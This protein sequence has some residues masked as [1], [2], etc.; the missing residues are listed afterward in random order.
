LEHKLRTLFLFLSLA[1]ISHNSFSVGFASMYSG[2]D[3]YVTFSWSSVPTASFD[4]SYSGSNAYVGT[5]CGDATYMNVGSPAIPDG[6]AQFAIGPNINHTYYPQIHQYGRGHNSVG[7]C[8]NGPGFSQSSPSSD[9]NWTAGFSVTTDQIYR[10]TNGG[11][12]LPNTSSIPNVQFARLY[13][14]KGTDIPEANVQYNIYRNGAYITT[15]AGNIYSWTEPLLLNSGSYTYEVRTQATSWGNPESGSAYYYISLHNDILQATDAT[16]YG[17]STLTWPNIAS[18]APNDIAVSRDGHQIAVVNKNATTYNDFDGVPGIV[19]SY[20][21]AP[22]N[23][24]NQSPFAFTDNGAS[25][26]NGVIKGNVRTPF[27]AAVSGVT[28]YGYARVNGNLIYDSVVTDASG[29]YQFDDLFYDTAAV[30]TIVPHKGLHH[31]VADTLSRRLGLNSNVAS[32]VDFQDTSVFTIQGQ[33]RFSADP[34]CPNC[35]DGGVAIYKD[36]TYTNVST[37]ANGRY[38]LAIQQEGTYT[39]KPLLYNHKFSPDSVVIHVTSD[40]FGVNFTDLARDTIFLSVKGG[41]GN[42]ISHHDIVSINSNNGSYAAFDTFNGYGQTAIVVPA[43]PYTV[44]FIKGFSTYAFEDPLIATALGSLPI[45]VDVTKRDSAT[46]SHVDTT[47]IVRPAIR[48]TLLTG[49]IIVHPAHTDTI[50]DTLTSKIVLQHRADFVYHGQ[51]TVGVVNFPTSSVCPSLN[52]GYI[53]EQGNN[54]SLRVVINEFYPYDSTSC[55]VD[56]GQLVIYD[57]VSDIGSAQTVNFYHGVYNYMVVP[58]S[59]NIASP[60]LK[61]LQFFAHVGNVTNPNWG[62]QILV[63]GHKPHTQTFVTKT[64]ELPFFVLHDPPGDAS[65]SFL[66]KDSSVSYNYS[67]SYQVGG[68]AGPYV[69]AKIGAGVPIPFTGVVIGA[70]VELQADATAG[71]D[72]THNSDVTTTFTASQQFSTSS[73]SDFV[74]GEGDVFVGGSFN[75]IYALTDVIDI[76]NCQVVRDTQLA[77]G[78]NGLATNYIYTEK[79]IRETLVPQLQVLKSLSHGDTVALIQSYIDVWNQVL[80]K[81]RRNR[82]TAA[83]FE[84]NISFSAGA[85]YDNSSSNSSDSTEAFDYSVFLDVNAGIGVFWGDLGGFANT[86]LGVKANFHW[87]MDKSTSTNVNISKTIG[88]HLEDSNPGDFMSVDVMKDHAYGT[89]SFKVVAGTTSCPH[90]VGTQARDSVN[91][92]LANYSVSN[93]P[94]N[95]PATFVAHIVNLSESQE[96][97]TYSIQ[98]VPESNLDGAIIKIGGQ[99]INNSPAS[100]TVPAGTDLPVVLTVERGPIASDYNGLQIAASSP[101]DGGEGNTLTFEAHFQSTCSPIGLYSPSDNWLI[102]ATNHDSLLVIFSGYNATDSNLISIGLEYRQ[103]G[104]SWVPATNP[105]IVRSRL[106]APYFNF[107]MNTASLPDGDY[108][109]R[110]YANCGSQ[111]GGKTYSQT[112]HGK[113]DRSSLQLFGTPSPSDGVLNITQNISVSFNGAV[114]CG[115][116]SAYSPIYSTLVRADNGQV[117][118]DS[119]TCNGNQLIIYTNPPSL[120]DSL[121]NVTLI[122][123]ISNVYDLN[124]NSLQQPITWSFLVSRSKV[125]WSP[126]NLNINAVTG[127]TASATANMLN[128]GSLDSFTIIKMPSWL[129]TP[130]SAVYTVNPGTPTT[131]SSLPVTF[132][133]VNSL[134]PGHYSDTVIALA[135]GKQLFLFV[136]LDV[137]KPHPNWNVNPANFQ[138]SM[139]VT[140]NYSL[141][142]LNAPLSADTRDTIAVFKGEECRGYAGISYDP[143]TNKY[144]AFITAY[145]NSVVGDTFTFRMWDAVPGTEYQAIERLAFINDGTIGQPLAPYVLHPEG[146]FQT[147]TLTPGWNWFSLNVRGNNMAPGKVLSHLHPTTGTVVK[148]DN[149]FAQYTLTP[150]SAGWQGTLSAF[151]TNKSYM[152]FLDHADTLRVLGQ[153]VTDTTVLQIA[154]GWNWIGYPRQNISDALSYLSN[155]NV[156]NGDLL[157]TQSSFTQYNAGNWSGTLNNMYPGQGYKLKTANAFNFVIP[158]SRSLP[159]WN[160]NDNLYQQNQSITAELQFDGAP[161]VQSHYLV[162]AFVNSTCIGT[163]QPLYIPSLNIYRV[164][165]TV[166]GDTANAS[167]AISFRVYD[168][169]N[170]IEYTPIY[171]AVSVVPDTTVAKIESP[172]V[173]NVQTTTGVNTISVPEGYSLLQ[174]VPNPFSKQ[175]SIEYAIPTSQHVIVT[176]Y[177]EAGR[178]VA[179]LVNGYQDAGKH[180]I[181]FDQENLQSGVYLDQMKSGDFVKTRRMLILK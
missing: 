68:S 151:T 173:I 56:S 15:V 143:Y 19:Y 25:R 120:I 106:I 75:M 85:P 20:A 137:I 93:V 105:P 50:I 34:H 47:Y 8:Y 69:D 171:D 13:W 79:H 135:N 179:E 100:F 136:N 174:N 44:N 108:E 63:T 178:I 150:T 60:Y 6:S 145:S 160:V 111:P 159:N 91:V 169:D 49:Q 87:N 128:T 166:H 58:G 98:A 117:I 71:R 18:F 149:A 33:I 161:V 162:G 78:A 4:C 9:I 35:Y 86:S 140:A 28:L 175:T 62:K 92:T 95:Q 97:R 181:S 54:T 42:Q 180:K 89:P 27:N 1:I 112:L 53:L 24:N 38:S 51:I 26:P 124:G 36:G 22:I 57:D 126:S 72:N 82:D 127:T 177:D 121:E 153:P 80:S 146:V 84:Q 172:Y 123:T 17:K 43:Q 168:T 144:V 55:P 156:S 147:V 30:Y 107:V 115:Q 11:Y 66:A 46:L 176:V 64:P 152:I 125:F 83:S 40:S 39:F 99:Q 132:T 103:P 74:G 163:A 109:V 113:I 76:K 16:L 167:Q 158:P 73:S 21:V 165:M 96:T 155:V 129:S 41:C 134:N 37:D 3:Y 142:Q 14:G 133:A 164:F 101:C 67:N 10:P 90:E 52:N 45:S 157:K 61:V 48:D 70:G 138:Y 102:N 77:W 110:A 29:F 114:D 130:Q 81:N 32:G 116:A 88:Y 5:S 59:P 2:S 154:S 131:P 170:D 122:A 23:S 65:F 94:I 31:F 139:N 148:T 118:P 7:T 119:V 12:N 141:T 104:G